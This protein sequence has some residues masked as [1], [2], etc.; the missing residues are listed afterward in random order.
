MNSAVF[1][2]IFLTWGPFTIRWYG[3][4][5]TVGALLGIILALHEARLRRIDP[6]QIV[7][8]VLWGVPFALIGARSY[9]VL[10]QWPFYAQHSSE[11]W[12]IWHGGLAI[13]GGLIAAL[14]VTII[15]THRRHL[16]VWLILDIAAPSVLIGQIVGRWG[17]FMNQEAFGAITSRSFLQNL[18]LPNW[19]IQQ[20]LINGHYRQP[21]FLY[22]SLWNL[23]GLII[24]LSLRHRSHL[25]KQG[26]VFLTYVIWYAFGRFFIEGMRTDSLY[27]AAGL[28]V[29]QIL[30]GILFV[31]AILMIIYRRRQ[32]TLPDYL[33][34]QSGVNKS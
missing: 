26:E 1:N 4:L 2:P 15:F 7:D 12:K 31:A 8:L 17:N 28:R 23:L 22:E 24:L 30:S 25:F 6:D 11:I 5:I 14:I 34:D 10:F 13:Y 33:A 29:S 18:H 27:L 21:T 3:L 19:I 16:P 9:Y 32:R 20:M